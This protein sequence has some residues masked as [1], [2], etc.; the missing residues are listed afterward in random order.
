MYLF[1]PASLTPL[2]LT[3]T[4][5]FGVLFHDSTIDMAAATAAMATPIQSAATNVIDEGMA[6]AHTHVESA[7]AAET[8]HDSIST[9]PRLQ[10]RTEFDGDQREKRFYISGDDDG[11]IWP[12]V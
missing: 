9:Q 11:I 6:Q 1:N 2:L 12:S 8:L 5:L 7:S 4:T 10:P 3:A